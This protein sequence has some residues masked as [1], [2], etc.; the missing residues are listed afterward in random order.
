MPALKI[1]GEPCA[2][3][4]QELPAC[5]ECISLR[6]NSVGYCVE[7]DRMK[8]LRNPSS[9]CV[10]LGLRR[11]AQSQTAEISMT[12]SSRTTQETRPANPADLSHSGHLHAKRRE[13]APPGAGTRGAQW[14]PNLRRTQQDASRWPQRS[15]YTTEPAPSVQRL[16]PASCGC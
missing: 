14:P 2:L 16:G 11:L 7:K 8:H 13:S 5:S 15:V 6:H 4:C 9:R 3:T 12:P 10:S 1:H